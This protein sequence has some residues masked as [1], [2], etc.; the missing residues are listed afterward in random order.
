ML[1]VSLIIGVL[2]FMLP[3]R[4]EWVLLAALV[5]FAVGRQFL[6]SNDFRRDWEAQTEMFWQ[7]TWRAP[8]LEPD[9]IVMMNEELKYYADNSLG[10]SLN[11]IYAPDNHSSHVDYVLFYPTNRL[12][13]SL[14]DLRPDI[15]VTYDYLAAQFE[16]NTSQMVA[17]YYAPPRCLRLL[18][19]EIDPENRFIPDDSLMRDAAR[20]SNTEQIL[21]VT[22]ARMPEMYGNEP[23]HNWCYY[24]ERADLARQMGD[25][26]KVTEL[27][28]IGFNLD[29]YPNDPLERFVFIEG[30]AHVGE[31]DKAL[32]YAQV[33]YKVSKKVV[34]PLL[35]RLWDRIDREVPDSNAKN[36]A[37][38]E[39]KTLFVCNP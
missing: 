3:R 14:V 20:L 16:G 22:V 13:S 11:L 39:A 35:C 17:F 30:Y 24:F 36:T 29:D 38:Q 9:T 26:K 15:P 19:P 27:G 37:V 6:W 32:Q 25:W 10:A 21:S 31:W 8:G 33:S 5:G 23:A 7:M 18:D 34:R 28:D 4:Y 12:G 1:G 2:V